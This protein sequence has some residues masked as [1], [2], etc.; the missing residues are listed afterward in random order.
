MRA[1][2]KGLSTNTYTKYGD[3][4]HD[5]AAI[6]GYY[7]SYCE[8]GTNNMIEVEHIHPI[9]HGGDEL[10]WDNFLLSCK[11]CNT[12]K[13]NRNLNRTGYFWPDIDNTDLLFEYFL[14]SRVLDV[15]TVLSVPIQNNAK[16]LID[17]VGLDRY[18]GN[19]NEPTEADTRWI[20]R[21]E[22]LIV[23]KNSYNN[24][25]LIKSETDTGS[26]I[27][28]IMAQ[29]IAQTSLIGFYSV[30]CKVFENEE[31]VLNEIEY[32]WKDKHKTFKEYHLGTTTRLI[33][34]RG[35]I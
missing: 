17:L 28:I 16:A 5:L 20:L 35:Q 32:L 2:D 29:Q 31:L 9:N 18:P 27:R 4:R 25:Y 8:M 14:D 15:N 21:D 12:V 10:N 33:R 11:Y 7:C 34:A 30:W 13:S 1:I 22:A 19:E 26:P 3:A 23:A 6:I 24:W